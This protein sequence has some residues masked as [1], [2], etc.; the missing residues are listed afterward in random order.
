MG[1][2]DVTLGAYDRTEVAEQVGLF[3]ILTSRDPWK[4]SRFLNFPLPPSNFP[5]FCHSPCP[6]NRLTSLLF[7]RAN[8]PSPFRPFIVKDCTMQF[9]TCVC[10][11]TAQCTYQSIYSIKLADICDITWRAAKLGEI[12]ARIIKSGIEVFVILLWPLR[13]LHTWGIAL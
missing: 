11:K 1:E 2:F 13:I 5:H 3:I 10:V 4:I 12:R 6:L 7:N 9:L 8:L